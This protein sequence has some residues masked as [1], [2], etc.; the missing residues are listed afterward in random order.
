MGSPRIKAIV[1]AN[2]A[3]LARYAL[4]HGEYILGCAPDCS[5]PVNLDGIASRHARLL[6]GGDG[7]LVV[8]S[9]DD[10]HSILLDDAPITSPAA[11]APNQTLQIGPAS[12][13]IQQRDS[14]P[15]EDGIPDELRAA[16][17][18]VPGEEIAKG[19]MGAVLAT[20]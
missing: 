8:E 13:L 6:V 10:A 19:G 16:T 18:Y 7:S 9:L 2:G 20:R 14:T 1:F 5:I 15:A 4:D 12:L 11:V 3:E 17:R